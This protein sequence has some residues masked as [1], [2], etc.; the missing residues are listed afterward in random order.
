MLKPMR[1]SSSDTHNLTRH[2][3]VYNKRLLIF[4]ESIHVYFDESFPKYVGKGMSFQ[5]IGVS[6]PDILNEADEGIDQPQTDENEKVEDDDHEEE[7]EENPVA[8]DN[9]PLSWRTSKDHPIDNILEDITRGV[10]THSKMSNF[11]Y[12]FAF[13]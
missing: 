1:V 10:T 2:I 6:S 13:V 11:C 12:H 5:D 3:R 9:F 8:V 7:N 4:E